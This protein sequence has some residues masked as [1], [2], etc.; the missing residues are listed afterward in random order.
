V[1]KEIQKRQREQKKTVQPKNKPPMKTWVTTLPMYNIGPGLT[2]NWRTFLSRVHEHLSPWLKS[3]GETLTILDPEKSALPA[4]WL[5]T[6]LLL[7]QTCGY[8]LVTSLA[9]HVQLLSTPIFKPYDNEAPSSNYHSILVTNHP[10][11]E[12]LAQCRGLR[13][14]C[15]SDDSNSGMNLLRREVAPLADR[16]PFF[17]SV[18]RTGSHLASLRALGPEHLADVA[19][20]DCITFAFVREHLPHLAAGVREI[21]R[22]R[23]APGLP[24]IAS[25]QVP[26]DGIAAITRAL[27]DTVAEDPELAKRLK[28]TG[29]AERPL[30]DYAVILQMETEA[31]ALGYPRLA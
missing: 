9:N 31:A 12:T 3:R 29:F 20:I 26:A 28:L 13:A 18:L 14:A 6:D 17:A 30:T 7:S 11:I 1:Q 22:T 21:G 2:A 23:S 27:S 19:A 10:D 4:L 24:M 16:K 25:N 15:N 8:P 5:R